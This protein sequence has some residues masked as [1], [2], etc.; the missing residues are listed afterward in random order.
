MAGNRAALG[1]DNPIMADTTQTPP[2]GAILL[3]NGTN[4]DGWTKR[5]GSPAVW[6]VANGEMETVGGDIKTVQKFTDFHLHIEF[7]CND[8]PAN[9]TGQGRAN[10]GVF[11]QGRYEIQVLDSFGIPRAPGKGDCGAVYNH[12]APLVNACLPPENWQ[13]YDIYFRAPRFD[14]GNVKTENARVTVLQNAQIIHNNVEI[15]APT[16]APV[17][18]N[19]WEP[20]PLLLQD[21]GNHVRFRNVWAIVLPPSGADYY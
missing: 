5:D 10:S 21:H 20:G 1:E 15:F 12:A 18:E 13:T 19:V 11:L 17:D 6:P 4:L 14:N 7:W 16:G 9:V 3:F 2:P 8:S